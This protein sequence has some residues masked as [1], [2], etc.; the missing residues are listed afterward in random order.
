[1]PKITGRVEVLVN[2]Q[3]MLTKKGAKANG[4]GISGQA[5][6]E[7][8][9]VTGENGIHGYIENPIECSVE[10]TITDRDDISLDALARIFENGTIIFRNSGGGKVYTMQ[11]ATCTGNFN[12]TSGEGEVPVKFIGPFWTESKEAS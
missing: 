3:L 1:M 6:F 10:F 12:L 2:G 7:R 11:N 5:P 4:L 9:P 8:A